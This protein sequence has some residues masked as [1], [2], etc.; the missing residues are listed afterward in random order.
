MS[1]VRLVIPPH[2][3][4]DSSQRPYDV[5]VLKTSSR[6]S[7]KLTEEI[8]AVCSNVMAGKPA[9]TSVCIHTNNT[10]WYVSATVA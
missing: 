7:A 6:D 2:S 4:R 10:L 5:L 3:L 9:R 1:L 8:G